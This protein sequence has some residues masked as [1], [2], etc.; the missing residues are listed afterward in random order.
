MIHIHERDRHT[1][2]RTDGQTPHDDISRACIDG[3]GKN[4]ANEDGNPRHNGTE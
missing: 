2:G 4:G 3:D 1:D